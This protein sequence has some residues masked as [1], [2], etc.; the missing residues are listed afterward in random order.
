MF[1]ESLIISNLMIKYQNNGYGGNIHTY[2]NYLSNWKLLLNL[3]K[4]RLKR[5]RLFKRLFCRLEERERQ[6]VKPISQQ[7]LNFES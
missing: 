6:S 4:Q 7:E 1:H 3:T 5:S 2:D